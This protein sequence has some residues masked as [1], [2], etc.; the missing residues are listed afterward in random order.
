MS[1]EPGPTHL[2]VLASAPSHPYASLR[3]VSESREARYDT[4]RRLRLSVPR[5][6]LGDWQPA[7]T[8]V[9]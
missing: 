2:N 5:E 6:S 9:A 7:G 8:P 1:D 3:R 4:G